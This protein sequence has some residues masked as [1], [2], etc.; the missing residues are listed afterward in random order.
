MQRMRQFARGK[1]ALS[2]SLIAIILIALASVCGAQTAARAKRPA[3]K[4]PP[5]APELFQYIRSALLLLSPD[6]GVDDNLEVSFDEATS[7]MSIKQPGGHCDQYLNAVDANNVAWDLYDPSDETHARER[8]LRMNLVSISGRK[9]RVCYDKQGQVDESIPANRV[10]LLFILSKA[11]QWPEFQKKM[12]KAVKSL[13]VL[14]GGAP[15][16]DIF[17]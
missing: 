5:T 2:A 11:E 9:A 13:V 3:P 1:N 10:R 7:I 8:L 17:K 4:P 6:D 12:T 16:Q 14:S 15:V